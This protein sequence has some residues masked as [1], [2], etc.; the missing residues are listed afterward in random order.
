MQAADERRELIAGCTAALALLLVAIAPALGGEPLWGDDAWGHVA[1][2]EATIDSFR[3]VGVGGWSSRFILGQEAYLFYGPGF[4]LATGALR[5]AT[6]GLLSTVG[7]V[8]VAVVLALLAY[9][10]SAAFLARSA[11]LSRGAAGLTAILSVVADSVFGVGLRGAFSTALL[12]QTLGAPLALVLLGS[13]LRILGGDGRRRWVVLL[14]VAGAGLC[15]THPISAVVFVVFGLLAVLDAAA[16]RGFTPA[17]ACRLA[18]AGVLAV[19]LGAVSLV[20]SFVHRDLTGPMTGWTTPPIGSRAAA[21]LHG[22]L[23]FAPRVGVIVVAGLVLGA[24]VL[25]RHRFGLLLVLGAPLYLVV[26]HTAAS[27]APNEFTL[28][29]A[30]RGLGY[31]GTLAVL[32]LAALL[33]ELSRRGRARRLMV[34]VGAL[35]FAW[36]GS[37]PGRQAAAVVRAPTR[38]AADAANTLRSDMS[39]G[40]RFVLERAFPEEIQ[41]TGL[42]H[43]DF[44]L[45]AITRRDTLNPFVPETSPTSAG[46]LSDLVGTASPEEV[47]SRLGP[48]GIS[49]V[50]TVREPTAIALL[51]SG[52]F[53]PLTPAGPMQVFRLVGASRFAVGGLPLPEQDASTEPERVVAT[54]TTVNP[55]RTTIA[56]AWSPKWHLSVDG[57]P[58]R[59]TRSPDGLLQAE[60]SAGTHRLE[61]EH[62]SDLADLVG[63]VISAGTA[64][65]L[66]LYAVRRRRS[67]RA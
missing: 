47:R 45:A 10:L 7:A 43:P 60:L 26:A 9:P 56:L 33:A 41:T 38:A 12:G 11:E 55:G 62:R 29:L 49:H 58:Q 34:L 8:K 35:T 18:A 51:A 3:R 4:P 19:A 25:A 61:L 66:L 42:V 50:V 16:R 21:I 52:G 30:N 53:E 1:R 59:L 27:R 20:P 22:E 57:S 6:F 39:P 44:W 67:R 48:L 54:V 40:D 36:I 32:P 28:Q 13:A 15:T 5:L 37:A 24:L 2:V 46:F 17:V 23:L 64:A 31:A 14:G 65:A 63:V